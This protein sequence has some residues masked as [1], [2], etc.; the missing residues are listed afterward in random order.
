MILWVGGIDQAILADNQNNA[1]YDDKNVNDNDKKDEEN[2]ENNE[3]NEKNDDK[4]M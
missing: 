1:H 4:K 3:N 2:D